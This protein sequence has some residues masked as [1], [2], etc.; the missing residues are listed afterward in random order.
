MKN[1]FKS[2]NKFELCLWL[3][4]MVVIAVSSLLGGKQGLVAEEMP[5]APACFDDG[6]VHYH[7]RK[8]LHYLS[9]EDWA[10]YIRFLD[11]HFR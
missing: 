10:A 1:P 6:N 4:S 7:L 3:S 9:T 11:K 5:Q 2:L 8:R